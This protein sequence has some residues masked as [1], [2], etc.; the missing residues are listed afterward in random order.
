MES[1]LHECR[2]SG[3]EKSLRRAAPTFHR[4]SRNVEGLT[5]RQT[6][7]ASNSSDAGAF[8]Y[9]IF[10]SE[11]SARSDQSRLSSDT[12]SDA[13]FVLRDVVWNDHRPIRSCAWLR[14]LL[15]YSR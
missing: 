2:R 13:D 8:S 6:V 3:G 7:A 12:K 14:R 10:C 11:S 1:A 5:P 9:R 15:G 4:S